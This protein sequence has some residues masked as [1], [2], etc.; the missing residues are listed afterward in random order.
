MVDKSAFVEGKMTGNVNFVTPTPSIASIT[1]ART[2]LVAALEAAVSGAHEHVVV[3]NEAQ[4]TL[5]DLLTLLARYINSA[6]NNDAD[7]AVSSGFELVKAA[8]PIDKLDAPELVSA[9][10]S[11]YIGGVDMRW[12]SVR[13]ARMYNVYITAGD[14]TLSTGWTVAA[15]ISGTKT[16]IV[17]LESGKYYSFRVTALG[18]IGEGPASENIG[19]RAA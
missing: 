2:A 7:V 14:P 3:K 15:V 6:S 19:S 4:Q 1:A 9:R 10:V 16:T 13:G 11:T 8:D 12:R 18:R 5:H 17:D